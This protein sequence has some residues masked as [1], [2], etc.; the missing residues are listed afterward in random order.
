VINTAS[1]SAGE[2]FLAFGRAGDELQH[3]LGVGTLFAERCRFGVER[4][5]QD[6]GER[7]GFR[8]AQWETLIR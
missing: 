6:G 8:E 3:R 1:L 7:V 5:V 4:C 2:Q